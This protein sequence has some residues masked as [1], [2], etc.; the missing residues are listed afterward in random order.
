MYVVYLMSLASYDN[1]YLTNR[2]HNNN[3]LGKLN[4]SPVKSELLIK[5]N[6]LLYFIELTVV[7]IIL[8]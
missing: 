6:I 7:N 2:I 8:H 4:K 5:M 3:S 1:T